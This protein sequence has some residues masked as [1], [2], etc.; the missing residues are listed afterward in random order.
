MVDPREATA[1]RWGLWA[2]GLVG[3]GFV[4]GL[5][6]VS[7]Y[8]PDPADG[9]TPAGTR[10]AYFVLFA[11]LLVGL[12]L[13][14]LGMWAVERRGG[15]HAAVGWRIVLCAGVVL[16]VFA[17]GFG[18]RT[19]AYP[20]HDLRQCFA[21]YRGDGHSGIAGHACRSGQLNRPLGLHRLNEGIGVGL[22]LLIATGIAV[23][24]MQPRPR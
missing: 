4:A 8:L 6:I 19:W 9:P 23:V 11:A 20:P 5:C 2:F 16:A 24:R 17:F 12:A 21:V 1:A 22:V 13:I 7:A 3:G 14:P 18:V 10:V 15:L